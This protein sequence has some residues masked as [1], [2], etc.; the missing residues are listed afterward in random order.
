ME[1]LELFVGLALVAL[2]IY[3]GL[4]EIAQAICKREVTLRFDKPIDINHR[5]D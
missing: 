3:E 2:A 4:S 1:K 5:S